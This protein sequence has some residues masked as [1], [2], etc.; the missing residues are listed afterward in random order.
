MAEGMSKLV[1]VLYI[2]AALIMIVGIYVA[3]YD[4]FIG[5]GIILVAIALI[6]IPMTRPR[7]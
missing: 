5:A 3:T 1:V 7:Y 4:R 6:I 2:I